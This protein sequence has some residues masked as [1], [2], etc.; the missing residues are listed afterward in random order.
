M[1][2]HQ[3]S[4]NSTYQIVV[5]SYLQLTVEEKYAYCDVVALGNL[6]TGVGEKTVNYDTRLKVFELFK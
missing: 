3:F 4:I 6:L 1:Q 2:S 5:D